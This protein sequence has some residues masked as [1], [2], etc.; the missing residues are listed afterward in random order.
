MTKSKIIILTIPLALLT[1][2]PL[3]IPSGSEKLIEL[4]NQAFLKIFS[5]FKRLWSLF[6]S[7]LRDISSLFKNFAENYL[8]PKLQKIWLFFKS[9]LENRKQTISE[10]FEKEKQDFFKEI[11]NYLSNFFEFIKKKIF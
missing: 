7:L 3:T 2:A 5:F 1:V 4:I 8:K 6:I 9:L 11:N 10:E